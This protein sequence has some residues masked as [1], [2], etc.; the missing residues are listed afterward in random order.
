M[1]N[2][3]RRRLNASLI[4]AYV[5]AG[6]LI[7]TFVISLV[8][9]PGT[10]LDVADTDF[11]PLAPVPT[12]R[13]T[14]VSFPTPEPGGTTLG[15]GERLLQRNGL[16][17]VTVP[18]GWGVVSNDYNPGIPRGRVIFNS[19]ERV[20]V[21]D[22]LLD[23]GVNYPDTQALSDEVFTDFYFNNAWINPAATSSY[24]R[25]EEIGRLVGSEQVTVDFALFDNDTEY[26]GRQV[27]W[28]EENRLHV[29][30]LVV[31]QNNPLLLQALTEQVPPTVVSYDDVLV[32]NLNWQSYSDLAQGYQLRHPNWQEATRAV[33]RSPR[34][35][36]QVTF[37][38]LPGTSLEDLAAAE[39][40][41][42]ENLRPGAQV[43]A[44]QITNRE[45]TEAGYLVSYSDTTPAGDPISG[46]L[47]LLVDSEDTLHVADIRLEQGGIDLLALE[48]ES[49]EQELRNVADSFMLLP[50]TTP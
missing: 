15:S 27:A 30:R 26:L 8:F 25:F 37:R 2:R 6:I 10:N 33:L 49:A 19:G 45:F 46:L 7:F 48:P 50:P 24:T 29:V 35:P 32:E 22:V 1:K 43:L 18:E 36:A 23:Y 3:K 12:L 13:P 16:F 42:A 9:V 4:I 28:L 34:L 11:D 5:F 21:I 14:R 40:L 47:T 44:A 20:S 41:V 39:N 38:S 31:P 17:E